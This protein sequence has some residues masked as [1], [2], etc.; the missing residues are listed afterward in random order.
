MSHEC[1]DGLVKHHHVEGYPTEVLGNDE[2]ESVYV[3]HESWIKLLQIN[4]ENVRVSYHF[5]AN[6]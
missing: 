1:V 5:Q 4:R 3:Q 2:M 6:V